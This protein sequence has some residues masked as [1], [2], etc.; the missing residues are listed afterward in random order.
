MR[1]IEVETDLRVLDELRTTGMERAC[2][3]L[4][5]TVA[6]D[7][8]ELVPVDTGTLHDTQR[9]DSDGT[10]GEVEWVQPYS[11]Y[12]YNGDRTVSPSKSGGAS[13]PHW[14][15]RAK[16]EHLRDWVDLVPGAALG[17]Q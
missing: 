13:C 17:V 10:E 1:H 8:N 7:S 11:R 3:A 12:V 6:H 14:F 2:A 5:E 9:F 16:S 4:T 15:E